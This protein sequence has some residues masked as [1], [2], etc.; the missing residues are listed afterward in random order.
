VK[1]SAVAESEVGLEADLKDLERIDLEDEK[2]EIESRH[3][4]ETLEKQDDFHAQSKPVLE[5]Q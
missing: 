3:L 2:L 5:Q 1:G 4:Q